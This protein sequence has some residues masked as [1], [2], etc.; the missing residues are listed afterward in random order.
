MCT[1]DKMFTIRGIRNCVARG[2]ESSGFF[3]V[4]TGGTSPTLTWVGCVVAPES[5]GL[6]SVVALP[7]GGFAVTNF[8]LTAGELWEWQPD[9]GWATVPGSET[10]GPNGLVVSPD[11]RWFYIGG[12]GTQSLIRLSRGQ[13]PVQKDAVDVGFHIDNV[14]WA[15][16][17]S[18]LAAGHL[19]DAPESIFQCLG[20]QQ[21]DGVTSRVAKVDPEDLTILRDRLHGVRHL[22]RHGRC[23]VVVEIDAHRP[24]DFSAVLAK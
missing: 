19:G 13:T 12:W 16:D 8:Q 9:A 18:L 14:R 2:Y 1:R 23:R 7:D 20:Q 24:L 5:V 6:N 22:G 21:C 15:P 10:N 3:E 17:G 4:D 11:G